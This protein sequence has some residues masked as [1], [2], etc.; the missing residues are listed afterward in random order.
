MCLDPA[1]YTVGQPRGTSNLWREAKGRLGR[2]R[3][4]LVGRPLRAN[5]MGGLAVS[6]SL[7]LVQKCD[8]QG[9]EGGYKG[10]GD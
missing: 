3:T 7:H 9:G 2:L 5:V 10:G 6:L 1:C 8:Y 4:R